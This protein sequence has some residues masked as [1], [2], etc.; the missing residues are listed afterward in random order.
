MPCM[1]IIVIT[2]KSFSVHVELVI[3][4]V[5]DGIEEDCKDYT[6]TNVEQKTNEITAS[7]VEGVNDDCK[8]GFDSSFLSMASLQCLGNS[9]QQVTYRATLSGGSELSTISEALEAWARSA[10]TIN[11]LDAK[12][13]V[14]TTCSIVIANLNSTGCINPSVP[15]TSIVV[16]TVVAAVVVVAAVTAIAV[17]AV[18]I[19]NSQTGKYAVSLY[20]TE[21]V[22]YNHVYTG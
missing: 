22:R 15:V 7:I 19:A 4:L 17:S 6:T 8:C 14:D 5:F 3:Q 12:L 18:A 9:P 2:K 21:S 11:V 1:Y 10:L 13:S 16:G 20:P